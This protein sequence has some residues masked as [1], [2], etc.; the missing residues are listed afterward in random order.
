M[1]SYSISFEAE[2]DLD[3]EGVG[4][5]FI[6]AAREANRQLHEMDLNDKTLEID[7]QLNLNVEDANIKARLTRHE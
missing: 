4:Q 1:S 3:A 6:D 7:D 5:T 2:L